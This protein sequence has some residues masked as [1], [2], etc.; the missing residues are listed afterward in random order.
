[1]TDRTRKLLA[2]YLSTMMVFSVFGSVALTAPAMAATT[3][4]GNVA[5]GNSPSVNVADATIDPSSDSDVPIAVNVSDAGVA[6]SD[7]V[8]KSYNQ[9]DGNT[10]LNA[11]GETDADLSSLNETGNVTIPVSSV[12]N[13]FTLNVTAFDSSTG[14]AITGAQ[15]TS[16][17]TVSDTTAPTITNATLGE[18]NGDVTITFTSSEKLSSDSTDIAVNVVTPKELTYEFTAPDFSESTN[19]SGWYVY[20]LSTSQAYDDGEGTYDLD[21][22][23]AKDRAGNDGA[24]GF[25]VKDDSYLLSSGPTGFINGTVSN[26]SGSNLD[27]AFTLAISTTNG[28][29]NTTEGQGSTDAN[30][31]YSY[32][33]PTGNYWVIAEAPGHQFKIK[34]GISVSENST[35]NADITLKAFPGKGWINGTYL[36]SNGNPVNNVNINAR[37]LGYRFFGSATTNSNGVFNIS[38]TASN[39]RVSAQPPQGSGVPG[40]T[41]DKVEVKEGQ[42]TTV[43]IQA[44]ATG[45]ITGTVE[46]ASGS[47]Q[48]NAQILAQANGRTLFS[49]TNSTGGYNITAPAGDYTVTVFSRSGTASSKQA[50]VSE[51]SGVQADFT[52]EKVKV[53]HSS[54]EVVSG[55]NG[56]DTGNVGAQAFVDPEGLLRA[57]VVNESNPGGGGPGDLETLGADENTEF[58]INITV[59]NYSSRA[60]LWGIDEAQWSTSENESNPNATDITV[61]GKPVN[62]QATFAAAAGGE[63]NAYGAVFS[64]NPQWASGR[65]D[66]ADAGVNQTIF[67]S[68]SQLS[69]VADADRNRLEGLNVL[70]NAQKFTIPTVVNNSLRLWIAG[71]SD[72]IR[73]QDHTGFYEA[74]IPQAQLDDW[75]VTDPK[76]DLNAL[77]KGDQANFTVT[78]TDKGA[79][80]RLTNISYS[81]GF[82]EVEATSS[83][84]KS[85]PSGGPSPNTGSDGAGAGGGGGPATQV[86]TTQT[87]TGTE[88]TIDQVSL[89]DPTVTISTEGTTSGGVS[90]TEVSATFNKATNSQSTMS[91]SA[92]TS[93]PSGTPDPPDAD[94]VVSYVDVTVKGTLANSISEGRFTVDVSERNV[95]PAAVTAQRYDGSE[96]HDVETEPIGD[97]TVQII[98]PDGYSA[99]AVSAGESA[100][101]EQ[102]T[103]TPTEVETDTPAETPTSAETPTAADTPA[104][105]AT[106]TP[107]AGAAATPTQTPTPTATSGAFGPGFGIVA[108]LLAI[109]AALGV[110]RLRRP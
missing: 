76:S 52:L 43:T 25:G 96:W 48:A 34:R 10:P 51:G 84:P 16:S 110:L 22:G 109:V 13:D 39:Y 62:L 100:D 102:P 47:A 103:T 30:G 14:N 18:S 70:T 69:S 8:I 82:A 32:E 73:G 17:I 35:T 26:E 95:D 45:Y 28:Q 71:P 9:T 44:P 91:V 66:R 4:S 53:L 92:S 72:T 19:S 86:T 40:T 74:E 58:R 12:T 106:P 37:D 54:A 64:D 59:T 55:S 79:R 15:G 3:N 33:V 61:R 5:V 75:G 80:I 11:Q 24:S 36:D 41:L 88:A 78:D 105:T 101:R 83:P 38:V 57:T 31:N 90:V 81:A 87:D 107:T 23:N 56:V 108:A 1:M 94:N 27:N 104:E 68:I 42:T 65:Q 2:V 98:S 85:P 60:L 93:P 77:Y 50:T 89:E 49:T 29:P 20:E 6:L 97:S 63:G 46:D 7:L 99:F 67:F 21:I